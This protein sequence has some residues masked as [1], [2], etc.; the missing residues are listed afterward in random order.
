MTYLI[1]I[2]ITLVLLAGFLV[3]TRYETEHGA[4]VFAPLRARLDRDVER[5]AFVLTHVDL[6]VFLRDEIR[7]FAHRV[8]HDSVHLSLQVVRAIERLLTRLVRYFRTRQTDDAVPRES[9]RVFV[10][11]LS[12]FKVHL[13]T[14]R[15]D[16]SEMP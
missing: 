9:T 7:H 4:R 5:I 8:G 11:T 12:D 1:F 13:K 10:Q 16:V 3:L 6:G 2:F 14:T 15:P